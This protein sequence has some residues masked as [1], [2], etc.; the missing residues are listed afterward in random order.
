MFKLIKAIIR[1]IIRRIRRNKPLYPRGRH[2]GC[3]VGRSKNRWCAQFMYNGKRISVYGRTK[4]E[5]ERR[6]MNKKNELLREELNRS[7]KC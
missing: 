2:K 1:K 7:K 3:V 4:Q 6:L 5:A